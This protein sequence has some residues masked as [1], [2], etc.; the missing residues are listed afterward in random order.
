MFHRLHSLD[1]QKQSIFLVISITSL[2][3]VMMQLVILDYELFE[4]LTNN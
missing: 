1:K 3:L 4:R 2:I